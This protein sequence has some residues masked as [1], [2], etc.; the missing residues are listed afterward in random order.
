MAAAAI[1]DQTSPNLVITINDHN[2][3]NISASE[4]CLRHFEFMKLLPLSYH[5]RTIFTSFDGK[6]TT[7]LTS[8][9]HIGTLQDGDCC[10]T[11]GK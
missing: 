5:Y 10:D 11:S 4:T 2:I 3:E 9:K 6:V 1:F 8:G 7:C